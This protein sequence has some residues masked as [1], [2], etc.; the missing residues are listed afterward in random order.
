MK[1][2]DSSAILGLKHLI[3]KYGS[4]DIPSNG[5]SMYPLIQ[6]GDVCRFIPIHPKE[7]L[8]KG[9][10]I[11]FVS[12]E[13]LLVGHRYCGSYLE[14]GIRYYIFK[15]DTNVM[16]DPPV[17][18]CQLIGKLTL[19]KKKRFCL[20]PDGIISKLWG[21]LIF[22]IPILPRYCKKYL[23]YKEKMILLMKEH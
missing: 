1:K 23:H 15:G 12:D 11:L 6:Q 7:E 8:N 16:M 18:D 10:I 5:V 20:Y 9:D 17:M 3:K 22:V 13:G 19:I 4:V 21:K 14:N 2:H